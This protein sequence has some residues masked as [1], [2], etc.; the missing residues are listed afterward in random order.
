MS[1]ISAALSLDKGKLEYDIE[2]GEEI[3][4][5]VKV[6]SEDYS[7][8]IIIRDIWP[9]EGEEDS[10]FSKYTLTAEDYGISIDYP[11]EILDFSGESEIEVCLSGE[12][13]GNFRG[14]LIFTPEAGEEQINVVVEIGTWLMV[15]ITEAEI[16]EEVVVPI[17]E[18]SG[19]S[20]GGGSG[21]GSPLNLNLVV[22]NE[23][24]EDI[25]N[26]K[27]D[28]DIEDNKEEYHKDI[29]AKSGPGITGAVVGGGNNN[30]RIIGI[31]MAIIVVAGIIIYNKRSKEY[32][33]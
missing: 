6:S 27:S 11:S 23:T 3:C 7:G 30:W 4:K 19:S 8:K 12:E 31:V 22:E 5:M 15:N 17:V 25:F 33:I 9:E 14:A 1:F 21:G 28:S 29:D 18:S 10:G 13:V 20:S 16:E 2:K 24:Q 26:I 32:K